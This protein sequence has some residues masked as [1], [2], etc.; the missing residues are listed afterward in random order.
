MARNPTSVLCV[1]EVLDRAS[2]LDAL[3]G[4]YTTER[5][6]TNVLIVVK[7]SLVSRE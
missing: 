4:T 6:G 7:L 5:N 3:F 1:G 2:I